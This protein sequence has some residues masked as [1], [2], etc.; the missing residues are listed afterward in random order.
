M[1][2]VDRSAPK[3]HIDDSLVERSAHA[4]VRYGALL[5]GSLIVFPSFS[6]TIHTCGGILQDEHVLL[7][8]KQNETQRCSKTEV[9]TNVNIHARPTEHIVSD[10]QPSR[11]R[12][13]S[14]A[15]C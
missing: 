11:S 4:C 2:L 3:L 10:L 9:I 1:T 5:T 14:L 7:C 15:R 6:F 8:Y 13:W 12:Q